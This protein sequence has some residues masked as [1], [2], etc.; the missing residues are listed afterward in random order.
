MAPPGFLQRRIEGA[1]RRFAGGPET[2]FVPCAGQG[3]DPSRA[4][5][6][7]WRACRPRRTARPV[8]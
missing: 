5:S 4:A 7:A 1:A 3:V 6:P 8:A 2:G